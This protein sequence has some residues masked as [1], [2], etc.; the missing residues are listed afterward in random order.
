MLIGVPKEIKDQEFRVAVVPA[1]VQELVARGHK[2][3]VQSGAGDGIG[4]DDSAYERVGAAIAPRAR[5]VWERADLI[6]KVKEPLESEWPMIRRGQVLFTYF[7]FASSRELTEAML[8]TGA[9]CIAYETVTDV[10]GTLPLLTPMSE[11][12]G[13][14]SVQQ[15]A[16]YLE[17]I[18]GGRGTLL[19][20]VP[21]VKPA[22]V[23]I[24][25][26][27]IVGTNAAKIAAGMGA[28]VTILDVNLDRLRY[29]D[30]IMPANCMTLYSNEFNIQDQLPMVDVVI[31]AVLRTGARAPRLM[32]RDYLRL[33]PRGAVLVDVAIDQGGCFETSRPTT[34]SHPI[35]EEEGIIHYCVTNMPGAVARSSTFALTNATLPYLLKIVGSGFPGC[36]RND[37]HLRNGLNMA[38]G[39]VVYPAVAEDFALPLHAVEEVLA[40]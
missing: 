25:G 32:K 16:K 9:V 35:Y 22:R 12:A 21:G 23:M 6:V 26:G 34:H 11:I 8:S 36:C 2:V 30:D 24:L 3:L 19:G 28:Q 4:I 15:G 33:L 1:G 40:Q 38:F 17:K 20:G 7:H 5:E 31:G 14:L 18:N 27:G 39:K 13:R 10:H 37:L 29:L